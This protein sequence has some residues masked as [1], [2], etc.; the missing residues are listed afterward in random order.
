MTAS[1]DAPRLVSRA[2]QEGLPEF[3]E[4]KDTNTVG[5]H[6]SNTITI[7]LDSISRFHA[8]VDQRGK[9]FIIQDLNSSNGTFVNGERITQ[10]TLNNND[11]V[12]F[13]AIEFL[14]VN[15][16]DKSSGFGRGDESALSIVDIR[17]DRQDAYK[18]RTESI[19]RSEDTK[20]PSSVMAEASSRTAD[21][22]TLMR[23]NNRL[24][25]LFR[26]SEMLRQGE[27]LSE[28]DIVERTLDLIFD[29]VVADRAVVM[30]RTSP[31]VDDLDVAA[32][33][34]R[35]Q[36]IVA[37]KKV[38]ISRTIL[39]QV[40]EQRVAILSR[41]SMQDDRFEASESIVLNKVRAVMCV[42]MV[43]RD[44]VLGVVHLETTSTSRTFSRDDLEFV[45]IIATELC[46]A[47]ENMRLRKDA[48][49]RERLAAVGEAM[50]G[51]S[52]N[53]KNILL[54]M[55]GGSDLL[56]RSFDKNDLEGAQ[57]SWG[58]VAR[59]I[60]KIG[61][62]VKEMLNYSSQRAPD[63]TMVDLNDLICA[64]AEEIQEEVLN[65]GVTL[66]LDLDER[67][68]PRPLDEPGLS[69]TLANLIVNSMEAISHNE[70]EIVVTT[71]LKD[72]AAKTIQLTVRDNGHGIPQE[73]LD[74]IFM[75]FFTTKGSKGTGLGLPMCKKVVEDM[76]GTMRVESE[77]GIGTAFVI[78]L[79]RLDD[80]ATQLDDKDTD[81]ESE[82]D[83]Y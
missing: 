13:G 69:R 48:E 14:F 39:E 70:G 15:D 60:E 3:F 75:P 12:T 76:G 21:K 53:I 37:E 32:V 26:L 55:Q 22:Q 80:S 61:R 54:L 5:R 7:P 81:A 40:T 45:H 71:Q 78:T 42:P 25:T 9:F 31:D 58:V 20:D 36:P 65:K 82:S 47:L 74:K 8:R 17:D 49:H 16:R 4:L 2:P 35:D 66:E 46:A 38:S 33:R 27:G 23:L 79:P 44:R 50:A 73:K 30:T 68:T 41:D 51:V 10:M 18:P 34:Y 62:L 59:G 72:D 11:A 43:R 52:H 28:A 63:L 57:D 6:P 56:S 67:I 29:A 77:E 1:K 19:I 64:T 24:S 83:S